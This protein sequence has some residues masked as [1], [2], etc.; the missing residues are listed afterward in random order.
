MAYARGV[1][2]VLGDSTSFRETDPLPS[3]VEQQLALIGGDLVAGLT[4]LAARR[5]MPVDAV[6]VS[7]T[8]TL[9]NALVHIGVI[10]EEGHPGF[11]AIEATVYVATDVEEAALQ[12]LW[13]EVL[14]RA[15]IVNTLSRATK[16]TTALKV[17]L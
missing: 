15:P 5:G 2:F 9:D 8:G 1:S 7:V 4:S 11:S 13:E 10:G 14:R 6:E 3:L 17:V 12:L 16:L